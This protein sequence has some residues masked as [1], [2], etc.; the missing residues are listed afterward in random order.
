MG[1]AYTTKG[2]LLFSTCVFLCQSLIN[3]LHDI[4]S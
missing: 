3:V 4:I 2:Q 1:F